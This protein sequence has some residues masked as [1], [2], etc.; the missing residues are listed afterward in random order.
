MGKNNFLIFNFF[1]VFQEALRIHVPKL[2]FQ[3]F[4]FIWVQ[5]DLGSDSNQSK[6]PL[7]LVL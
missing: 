6:E 7:V 4:W 1:S 3:R 5:K 2:H